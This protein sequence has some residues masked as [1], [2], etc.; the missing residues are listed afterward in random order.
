[1][2][3]GEENCRSLGFDGM[4]KRRGL[5]KGRGALSRDKAVVAGDFSIDKKS[6]PLRMT[7]LLRIWSTSGERVLKTQN[8]ERSHGP[9][10]N[11]GNLQSSMRDWI[12]RAA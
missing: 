6:Q 4:T 9:R 5:F 1:L 3:A 2:V 8:I 10:R 11:T 12:A 7:V